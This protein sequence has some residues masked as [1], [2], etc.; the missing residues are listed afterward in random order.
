MRQM[1]LKCTVAYGEAREQVER[2]FILLTRDALKI[3]RF[4]LFKNSQVL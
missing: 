4:N 3:V 1:K 2:T